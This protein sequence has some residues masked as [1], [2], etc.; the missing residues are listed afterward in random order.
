M[1]QDENFRDSPRIRAG[2]VNRQQTIEALTRAWREGRI[3][4][5][6]FQ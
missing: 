6:E 3:N 1:G 5:D 4:R 2:D